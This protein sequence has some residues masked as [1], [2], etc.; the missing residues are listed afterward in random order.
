MEDNKNQHEQRQ[1]PENEANM[2]TAQVL[3]TI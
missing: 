3:T 1:E 2:N